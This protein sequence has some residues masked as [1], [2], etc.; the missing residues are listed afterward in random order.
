[1]VETPKSA[2]RR[3]ELILKPCLKVSGLLGVSEP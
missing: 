2:I 1:M 3:E